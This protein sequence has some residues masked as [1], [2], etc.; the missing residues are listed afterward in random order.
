MEIAFARPTY[1]WLLVS[2]PILAFLHFLSLKYTKARALE[3]VNLPALQRVA[4]AVAM[5]KNITLLVIRMSTIL[6][7]VLAISGTVFSYVGR[8]S[9]FD[10][11]L[12]I[13][14]SSSMLADDY[15]PSRIEAAKNSAKLFL[16]EKLPKAKVGVISFSGT[17]Y[18]DIRPTEEKGKLKEA[19]EKIAVG[20]VGGTDI[21]TAI[22]TATNL[23]ML[24]DK[25][26]AIILLSDGRSNVGVPVEDGIAYAIK[27]N[28]IINTIGIG[29]EQGGKAS[30]L[31]IEETLLKL[32]EETLKKAANM[33][34]GRYIKTKDEKELLNAYKEVAKMSRRKI[35]LDLTLTLS[36]LA[37]AFLLIEYLLVTTRFRFIAG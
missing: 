34:A 32:D 21:G 18:I 24:E 1:L 36:L 29:T 4:K 9:D 33:T 3:F 2:I 12:A 22:I 37:L 30:E 17:S 15:T 19:I 35:F 13:D 26:K 7:I 28:V 16:E 5:P 14:A 10:F 23:L 31:G 25:G 20:K 27:Q 8:S 6:F 11:V